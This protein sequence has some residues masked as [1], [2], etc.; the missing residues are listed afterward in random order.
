M[1]KSHAAQTPGV[2][3]LLGH[4]VTGLVGEAGR[5]SGVRVSTP[6]GER[7][8]RAR[9]VV[10]PVAKDSAMAKFTGRGAHTAVRERA[11]VGCGWALQ[12][13]HWLAEAVAPAAAAAAAAAGR[14]DLDRSLVVYARRHRRRLRGHQCLAADFAT[15]RL[16]HP[17]ERLMFSV[18]ARDESPSRH[19]HLFASRLINPLRFLNP[20]AV[21]KASAV[22]IRHRRVAAP[23][24]DPLPQTGKPAIAVPVA[25]PFRTLTA[26]AC[27]P[28]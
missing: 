9:L 15:G 8:I 2:G 16:L 11:V 26:C 23:G 20:V 7:E 5:T 1:I 12:S 10:G 17:L 21:A 14:G 19:M 27:A 3:L 24:R 18:A 28:P 13:A 22:D 25:C 6:Q 4:Q